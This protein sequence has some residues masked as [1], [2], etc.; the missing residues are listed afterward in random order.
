MPTC[1]GGG[2]AGGGRVNAESSRDDVMTQ[3]NCCRYYKQK[4]SFNPKQQRAGASD[5]I[6]G[7]PSG[8]EFKAHF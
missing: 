5:E 2:D 7:S 8:R 6:C 1:S 3:C 4:R